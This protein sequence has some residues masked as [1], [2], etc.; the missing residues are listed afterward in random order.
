MSLPFVAVEAIARHS[1]SFGSETGQ[2]EHA[3]V[4]R[5][6]GFGR[7][8]SKDFVE[9]YPNLRRSRASAG[10]CHGADGISWVAGR[11]PFWMS[12]RTEPTQMPSR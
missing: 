9:A 5:S 2:P 12:L 6:Q 3:F 8:A 7:A 4:Q 1:A 11:M 10:I